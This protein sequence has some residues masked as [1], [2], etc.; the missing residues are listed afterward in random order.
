MYEF[1]LNTLTSL[2]FGHILYL[3]FDKLK[4]KIVTR[5]EVYSVLSVTSRCMQLQNFVSM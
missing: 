5:I 2:R 3:F 1:Q 4:V